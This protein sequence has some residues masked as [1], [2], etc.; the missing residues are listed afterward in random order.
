MFPEPAD[1][2]CGQ[3]CADGNIALWADEEVGEPEREESG[4]G[5]IVSG[6]DWCHARN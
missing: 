5:K 6:I 4:E 2:I 1:V 3:Q